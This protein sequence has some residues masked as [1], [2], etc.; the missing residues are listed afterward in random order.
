MKN[1]NI[2]IKICEDKF[3]LLFIKEF[4]LLLFYY[5]IKVKIKLKLS[6]LLLTFNY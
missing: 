6:Q 2:S 5:F 1:I 3:F 4:L